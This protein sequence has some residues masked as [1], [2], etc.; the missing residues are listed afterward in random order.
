MGLSVLHEHDVGSIHRLLMISTHCQFYDSWVVV[1]LILMYDSFGYIALALRSP[2][3]YVQRV[4]EEDW[5]VKIEAKKGGKK[6]P[7][8]A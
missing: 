8:R 6:V 3:K 1:P 7:I 2:E 4:R 5:L